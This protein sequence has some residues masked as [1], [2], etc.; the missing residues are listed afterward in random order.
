MA[1][2]FKAR[3]VFWH[4]DPR[5]LGP[6]EVM[7]LRWQALAFVEQSDRDESNPLP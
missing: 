2:G 5:M 7:R 1:K 6:S 4:H 3:D